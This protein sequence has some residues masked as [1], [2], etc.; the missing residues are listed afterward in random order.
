MNA[1]VL[2]LGNYVTD[3]LTDSLLNNTGLRMVSRQ[4]FERVLAEQNIQL[5]AQ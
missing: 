4:D 1:P 3:K 2:R 5:G